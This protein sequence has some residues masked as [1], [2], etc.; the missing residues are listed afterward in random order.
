VWDT[1]GRQFI[2]EKGPGKDARWKAAVD[3]LAAADLIGPIGITSTSSTSSRKEE[4][5]WPGVRPPN[6]DAR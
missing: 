6:S 2:D 5:N 1:N 3:Q 4:R